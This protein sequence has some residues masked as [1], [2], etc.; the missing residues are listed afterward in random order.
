MRNHHVMTSIN[1][2]EL[3]HEI[4][5]DSPSIFNVFVAKCLEESWDYVTDYVLLVKEE[6]LSRRG[7]GHNVWQC[8]RACL[9]EFV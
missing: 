1:R 3:V 9:T 8:C 6:V 7:E 2:V 4:H 5:R